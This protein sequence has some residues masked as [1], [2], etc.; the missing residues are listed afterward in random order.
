MGAN[1]E[2]KKEIKEKRAWAYTRGGKLVRGILCMLTFMI[3]MLCLGLA[4]YVFEEFGTQI[5]TDKNYNF[6]KSYRFLDRLGGEAE[7]IAEWVRNVEMGGSRQEFQIIDASKGV[8]NSY[9]VETMRQNG[10]GYFE[11]PADIKAYLILG[12]DLA[13]SIYDYD[14]ISAYL[15]AMS[16]SGKSYMYFDKDAFE[17]IFTQNGIQNT[18]NRFSDK[19]SP[20]A[21][22]IYM[23]PYVMKTLKGD[24]EDE[25]SEESGYLKI[26]N[27][28][29]LEVNYSLD[30]AGIPNLDTLKYAVYDPGENVFYSTWDDYFV[31]CDY[32]IYDVADIKAAI[33]SHTLSGENISSII[34]P[35]LWSKNLTDIWADI[36]ASYIDTEYA[37]DELAA[38]QNSAL[39]YYI[40]IGSGDKTIYSNVKSVQEVVNFENDICYVV[41]GDDYD[42]DI[43]YKVWG[44]E[45]E[46]D[47]TH[48]TVATDVLYRAE[49]IKKTLNEIDTNNVMYF[50]I[51][52]DKLFLED[53]SY[54]ASY[55][56]GYN[57]IGSNI[58]FIIAGAIISFVL[59]I[60][61]AA[62]LIVTTGRKSRNDKA[63]G[64]LALVGI[65]SI[66]TE[67]WFV[68]YLF[69]IGAS[70]LLVWVAME[71]TENRLGIN[72]FGYRNSLLELQIILKGVLC[73]LPFGIVFMEMTLSLARR[74][75]AHNLMNRLY[76]IKLYK[77]AVLW[78][79]SKKSVDRL[80]I[81][82]AAYIGIEALFM[83][84]MIN[85]CPYS[86]GI[87]II[88]VFFVVMWAVT[89][90][91]M[92]RISSDI[93]KLEGG[94]RKITEGDFDTRVAIESKTSIFKELA[95]GVNHIGDGLKNAVETSLKDERMK[96][97][98]ITNV[99]HDLKTPL[100]SI[101]NYIN[102]LKSEKMPTPEAEHYVEVLDSKAHRLQQLTED[103]VEA[104]KATSGNIELNMMPLS[105]EEL[106]KQALGE[107][108]DKFA[109][110]NLTV[111][112]NYPEKNV[113]SASDESSASLDND[114]DMG[115]SNV[116]KVSE[117]SVMVMADG[118]RLFRILD[119]VLQ[120]AYK[121]AMEGTRIY[122]DLVNEN[123]QISF[124]MKNISKAQLN[125]SSDEL[126]ERF[127]R[128][129]AS[130][131][132]EGSG[133]GLSI[134]KDLARLMNG[135]FELEL[136]GDLF[137]VRITLPEYRNH[138]E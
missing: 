65:D 39:V 20:S 136:D 42:E 109:E 9:N 58:K 93:R 128:G 57:V 138:I 34:F 54:I 30:D 129:D 32:Y 1:V 55:L 90:A 100:T 70:A 22:F 13:G 26:Y 75:K 105:F 92:H 52:R 85:I 51:D 110:K 102:L 48:P 104:A 3:F 44:E 25:E 83:A 137:K 19:F 82:T 133:L 98:L 95:S 63:E 107:F 41:L 6:Y 97:E 4:A 79:R 2:G 132:T 108:E 112:A 86:I 84:Y 73:S 123:G 10:M 5:L 106:V 80:K 91:A 7:G 67:L 116:K 23:D 127:T 49:D 96:T 12:K 94:V 135:D 47:I 125:I 130:R 33:A 114:D 122:I 31:P 101:I 43:A 103:L 62:Y 8:I 117:K 14:Y 16:G 81:Y 115:Q 35:L 76:V 71:M 40:E 113:V 28:D 119:N 64:R 59:L 66:S 77:E 11:N 134:A 121:Y 46:G 21:Y 15:K 72:P 53:K 89:I 18:G 131:T 87:I 17:R 78:A 24:N 37:R 27:G 29:E 124:I 61:Q 120:N 56:I 45:Y 50:A 68:I 74:I 111:V 118:R 99:S 126:M 69:S 88:V 36:E 38:R 60:I